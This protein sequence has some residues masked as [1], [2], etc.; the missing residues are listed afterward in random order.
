M[1]TIT[2]N[3]HNSNPTE[4]CAIMAKVRKLIA[5]GYE[6]EFRGSTKDTYRML[7]VKRRN[8]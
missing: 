6:V 4:D 1:Q 5:E 3:I 8:V 7:A 2:Y